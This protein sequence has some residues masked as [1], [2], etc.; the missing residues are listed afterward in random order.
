LL[1]KIQKR[2]QKNF[3]FFEKKQQFIKK[4]KMLALL[5]KIIGLAAWYFEYGGFLVLAPIIVLIALIV[6]K[7]FL[8]DNESC[9]STIANIITHIVLFFYILAIAAWYLW[10]YL[11]SGSVLGAI[12]ELSTTAK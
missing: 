4:K 7:S 8:D 9:A 6:L 12:W 5:I 1:D 3:H 2:A 11:I 10:P